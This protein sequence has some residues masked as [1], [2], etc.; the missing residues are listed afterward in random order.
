MEILLLR[1]VILTVSL[2]NISKKVIGSTVISCDNTV[3]NL[4]CPKDSQIS[5]T[6]ANYGR[7]SISVCNEDARDDLDTQCDTQERSTLILR[8]L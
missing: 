8:K 5:V 7:Y 6:R 2:V 3:L 4:S 1:M